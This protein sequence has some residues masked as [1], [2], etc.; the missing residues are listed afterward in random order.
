MNIV[1]GTSLCIIAALAFVIICANAAATVWRQVGRNRQ[2]VAAVCFLAI[3]CTIAAQKVS[4][5]IDPLLADAGTYATND[6]F[7]VA[8]SNASA[9]AGVDFS[10]SPLLVYARQHGMTNAEDWV[11]LTPRLY[12]A[13]QPADYARTNATNFDYQVFLDYVPPSPV[14]TN[15]V[16]ELHGFTVATNSAE[17]A[18]GFINSRPIIKEAQ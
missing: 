18:A 2:A 15:G 14:H 12:F 11:E 16:F 8:V 7:H 3:V 5:R 4:I 10:A 9:Y 6:V 1:V 13:Q 17:R